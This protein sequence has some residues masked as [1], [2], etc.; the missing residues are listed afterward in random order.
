MFAKNVCLPKNIICLFLNFSGTAL[1][2]V[3]DG[4]LVVGPV[5]FETVVPVTENAHY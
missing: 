5:V 3:V 1:P 2:D 4:E